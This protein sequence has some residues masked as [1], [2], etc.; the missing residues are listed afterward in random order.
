VGVADAG[1][2]Q[3]EAMTVWMVALI[4]PLAL[5]VIEGSA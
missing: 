5:G 2:E 3:G 4:V 1:T